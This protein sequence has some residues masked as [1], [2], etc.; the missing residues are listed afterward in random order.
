MRVY[1]GGLALY[2]IFYVASKRSLSPAASQ[3]NL[4]GWCLMSRTGH[5]ARRRLLT[6]TEDAYEEKQTWKQGRSAGKGGGRG[7]GIG[8]S[9]RRREREREAEVEVSAESEIGASALMAH[10][11]LF[12]SVWEPF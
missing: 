9:R 2:Q 3:I 8:R 11:L 1:C 12:S 10:V 6:A 5:S 7:I 4:A